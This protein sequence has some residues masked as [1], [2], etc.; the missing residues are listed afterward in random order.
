MHRKITIKDVLMYICL[1]PNNKSA[2]IVWEK[3]K[4]NHLPL[5]YKEKKEHK[6]EILRKIEEIENGE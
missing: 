5:W 3:W 2:R 4:W 1:N 6:Q